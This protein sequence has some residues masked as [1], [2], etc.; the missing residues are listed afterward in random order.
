MVVIVVGMGSRERDQGVRQA[1]AGWARH[2]GAIVARLR[3]RKHALAGQLR[4]RSTARAVAAVAP[5]PSASSP[6]GRSP[7]SVL[8]AGN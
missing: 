3:E 2:R 5:A 1:G 6:A 8:I 7:S 4:S